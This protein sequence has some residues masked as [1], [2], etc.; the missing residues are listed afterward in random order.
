MMLRQ[1]LPPLGIM[2]VACI[3]APPKANRE[4][5]DKVA[6]T[7]HTIGA[8][9]SIGGYA[10]IELYTLYCAD[11]VKFDTAI[12]DQRLRLREKCVRRTLIFCCL[13]CVCGFQI[14]GALDGKGVEMFGLCCD[15]E[16]SEPKPEDWQALA[17][18]G[19]APGEV[20]M[21]QIAAFE[22][23]KLLL[24]TASG[25][26]LLVKLLEYWF[27]VGAGLFM[28]L[29]HMAIW[30]YCPERHCDLHEELPNPGA[31]VPGIGSAAGTMDHEGYQS[32]DERHGRCCG[33]FGGRG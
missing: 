8:V 9:M 30:Y 23:K 25:H 19:Y 10:F 4:F 3:A 6:C 5:T 2:L 1:F 24:Q 12:H 29:S 17:A 27:E 28:L 15:D 11:N 16:W 14:C 31:V 21:D 13:F 22:H 33:C 18:H 7:I 20:V 32:L 26:F